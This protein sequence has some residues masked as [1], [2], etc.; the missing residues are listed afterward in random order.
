MKTLILIVNLSLA[1]IPTK[2]LM[3]SSSSVSYDALPSNQILDIEVLNN[4]IYLSSGE[5]LGKSLSLE[6]GY[7]F[8]PIVSDEMV[9][10]GNPALAINGDIIAVSGSIAVL[11]LGAMMP[12]GTGI[13]YSLD[14]GQTWSYMPQP[15]DQEDEDIW[16][17]SNHDAVLYG[18]KEDCEL[19]C[20]T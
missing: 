20:Q 2:Y 17:C 10:G 5:G 4:D 7:S 15:I 13:S 16:S 12:F 11:E 3:P 18:N 1:S 19:N 8:N 6:S 14:A 9:Q